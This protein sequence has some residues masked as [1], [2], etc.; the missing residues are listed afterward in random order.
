MVEQIRYFQQIFKAYTGSL[1][2]GNMARRIGLSLTQFFV[3]SHVAM[4][5]LPVITFVSVCVLWYLPLW[6]ANQSSN[7]ARRPDTS[8]NLIPHEHHEA[9]RTV[10]LSCIKCLES[11]VQKQVHFDRVGPSSETSA[12]QTLEKSGNQLL[13]N[14]SKSFDIEKALNASNTA[15]RGVTRFAYFVSIEGSDF[16]LKTSHFRENFVRIHHQEKIDWTGLFEKGKYCDSRYIS[17]YD[18]LRKLRGPGMPV[19]KGFC[20]H[21]NFTWLLLEKAYTLSGGFLLSP[22]LSQVYHMLESIVGFFEQRPFFGLGHDASAKQF[23]YTQD[24]RLNLADVDKTTLKDEDN[25]LSWN[26]KAVK[27][28][29][30]TNN[31]DCLSHVQKNSRRFGGHKECDT[32]TCLNGTCTYNKQHLERD[33]VCVLGHV[34]MPQLLPYGLSKDILTSCIGPIENRPVWA[35]LNRRI[36]AMRSR[37]EA[38]QSLAAEMP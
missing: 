22:S 16:V 10:N 1:H 21:P 2:T 29:R 20:N 5:L 19:V 15:F 30:C 3:H 6:S 37:L 25:Y 18:T 27:D 4:L 24:W 33:T 35:I 11:L 14:C 28:V 36:K 34:V 38:S 12:T 23:V 8:K 7:K 17:E 26:I 32:F 13:Y 9:D 31:L